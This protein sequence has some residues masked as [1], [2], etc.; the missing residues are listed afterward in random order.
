M[1]KS[2]WAGLDIGV[3]TTSMCVIDDAGK[4][5]QEATCPST[6]KSIHAEIRWLKRRRSAKVGLEAGSGVSLARGLR[7]L[8]YSIEIYEARQLSKFLRVRR[9]KTDAGD[10]SGIAEA[11]RI[12]AS[13]VSKVYLKSLESQSLQSRLTIRRHLIRERV[14]AVN[15]LCRQIELYG[16]RVRRSPRAVHL[17]ER[18]EAQLRTIFG[19]TS[20]PLRTD[21]RSLL[22][23]C[24]RMVT[25]QEELDK[26][27][28]DLAFE[29]EVC[30]RFME[31]PGVGPICALTFYAAIGEPHRFRRSADV[32]SYLGLTPRLYESG[33]TS[34]IGRISKM[35]NRAVR[36][37]LTHA[38][39]RLMC[40]RSDCELRQWAAQV[41]QRRG[42]PR[43]RI[44]L[45]RKLAVVMLAMW[46]SGE[47]YRPTSRAGSEPGL[48]RETDSEYTRAHRSA[49]TVVGPV[50]DEDYGS[51]ERCSLVIGTNKVGG[52]DLTDGH[53]PASSVD[54]V[55]DGSQAFIQPSHSEVTAANLLEGDASFGT[56]PR[57]HS[58]WRV[59]PTDQDLPVEVAGHRSCPSTQAQVET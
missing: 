33:L 29:S 12:G 19:K 54:G 22:E 39:I 52:T 38:S 24:Q 4:V 14:A 48:R 41:E 53:V 6:L 30:R 16:G 45:A 10:A 3:E 37:L 15:L 18:V 9:N 34:R 56:A 42:R 26:E 1:A 5:L 47:P 57:L 7:S 49:C 23:H 25:Y 28:E 59:A 43:A 32:G 46:K 40:S 11:G 50:P 31:I 51:E 58:P 17:R 36:S 55:D 20:P 44:A 8:G 2:I 27:L 35:G 13:M 21:L